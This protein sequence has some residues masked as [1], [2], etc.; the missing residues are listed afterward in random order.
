MEKERLR[1]RHCATRRGCC[2]GK[3]DDDDKIIPVA[4]DASS[5][6][7]T[8]HNTRDHIFF[9]CEG[10]PLGS[11]SSSFD[12]ARTRRCRCRC[13]RARARSCAV[14]TATMDRPT[15]EMLREGAR[16]ATSQPEHY[17]PRMHAL[18]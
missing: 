5:A 13:L 8:V 3:G 12:L 18:S 10:L 2:N 14:R 6:T 11:R 7:G 16:F 15:Q 17:A 9:F 4:V 1:P